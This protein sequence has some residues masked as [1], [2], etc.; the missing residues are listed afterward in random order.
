MN[1]SAQ[2]KFYGSLNDFLHRSKRDA[3]IEYTFNNQPSVK[4][5]IEAI[6]IPHVEV[7][8]ILVNSKPVDFRYIIQPN[9]QVEVMPI[10]NHLPKGHSLIDMH[11]FNQKF[12]LDVHLGSLA[13]E[14]RLM[15][16]DSVYDN[17]YLNPAM[18]RI[19][20]QEKRALLTRDIGL[21]KYKVLKY[22]YWLRS[23]D[24]MKQLLEVIKY[25]DLSG[26][27]KPFTRCIACN[28]IIGPIE[29]QM[30]VEKL[31]S[32]T[33]NYFNE[34]YQCKNCK[35]VYWK[36]SHYERMQRFIEQVNG[37]VSRE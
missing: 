18:V 29:K 32:G 19:A 36:G 16:F 10:H 5:A 34:F 22:G 17:Q 28:G 3:W 35:R 2:F 8:V 26:L 11:S 21:L 7:D 9:D 15:G 13:R 12:V 6:G 33:I 14:L 31:S 27:F 25:F 24:P 4:D 23:Q 30:I 20:V 37:I 1:S